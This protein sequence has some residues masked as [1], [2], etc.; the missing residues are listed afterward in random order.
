VARRELPNRLRPTCLKAFAMT[1]QYCSSTTGSPTGHHWSFSDRS[2]WA[3]PGLVSPEWCELP[4]SREGRVDPPHSHPQECLTPHPSGM[5]TRA[6]RQRPS[7]QR[8]QRRASAAPTGAAERATAGGSGVTGCHRTGQGDHGV[9][10]SVTNDQDYRLMR[11]HPAPA[12]RAFRVVA[13]AIV[14]VGL[15]V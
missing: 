2:S 14:A 9:R 7:W 10:H 11:G 12:T 8:G 6:A 15:Q 4:T 1:S 13:E 5:N 3:P